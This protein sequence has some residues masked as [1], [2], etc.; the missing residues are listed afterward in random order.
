MAGGK[1]L[2]H[3][4]IVQRINSKL[5]SSGNEEL[6]V[7][8]QNRLLDR[9]KNQVGDCKIEPDPADPNH[10]LVSVKGTDGDVSL[11]FRIQIKF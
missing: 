4:E 2:P 6:S 8:L 11:N 7:D 10:V 9:D 5:Y 3:S 1:P